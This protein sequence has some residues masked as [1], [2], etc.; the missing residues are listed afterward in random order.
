MSS[1][2]VSLAPAGP[3][4]GRVYEP[5]LRQATPADDIGVPP[6][7]ILVVQPNDPA[8][9]DL[10]GALSQR[11]RTLVAWE[12]TL[13][14]ARQAL[15]CTAFDVVLVGEYLADGSGLSLIAD[16]ANRAQRWATIVLADTM[17]AADAVSALHRGAA[18]VIETSDADPGRLLE[19]LENIGASRARAP[20]ANA[21]AA[22]SEPMAPPRFP[23]CRRE[24]IFGE[25]LSMQQLRA[26]VGRIARLPVDVLL[27]GETGTGKDL[28]MQQIH[29]LSGRRGPL[30]ALNCGAIPDTL[31]E[32]ELFGHELGAFTGAVKSRP[33]SFERAHRGTLFLDEI[34][35]MPMNQQVKLLRVLETRRV[36]R[37]GGRGELA[38]DL[39][40]IAASQ[41]GLRE[42]CKQG[43]FRLDLWHRLSVASLELPPLRERREDVLPLFQLYVVDACER[44]RVDHRTLACIDSARLIAYGWP[45]NVRELKHAAERFVLG[46]QVLPNDGDIA[47][48]AVR[49]L[50]CQLALCERE[51]IQSALDRHDSRLAKA[52]GDL[53]ISAKTL[54]RRMS[55]Y[56]M[57][58]RNPGAAS[59]Q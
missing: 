44:F 49:P 24:A 27:V 52:A 32:S 26:S 8:G 55:A 33:G 22:G 41:G 50:A 58:T 3:R 38:L 28:V 31:F 40:V 54:A 5:V 21:T 37:V 53:G 34:D 1:V 30:V 57:N 13:R 56:R 16:H 46:L 39:R 4:I 35:S 42:R 7:S 20:V 15:A 36:E 48:E 11:P 19:V 17:D 29:D 10:L 51:L 6:L 2:S 14:Q 23:E 47:A 25:A 12:R 43:L 59:P 45:G 9:T 18:A